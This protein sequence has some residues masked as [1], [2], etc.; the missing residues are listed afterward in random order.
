MSTREYEGHV[1]KQKQSG[2]QRI[3]N[4][5]QQLMARRGYAQVEATEQIHA[6]ISSVV[7][8]DLGKQIVV[9][10]INRGVLNVFASDSVVLQELTFQ[11][12][13]IL[14]RIKKELPQAKITD[15][16]FKVQTL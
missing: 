7:T 6:A 2:V 4:L 11:K 9:G 10:K 14:K 16:R 15:I 12:R 5:V 3:G 8:G 1:N 13:A